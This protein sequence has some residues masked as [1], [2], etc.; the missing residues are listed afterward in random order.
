M[1]CWE[2]K[3]T[4]F[5]N[6]FIGLPY[7]PC[8][9]LAL[10]SECWC[11]ITT[12]KCIKHWCLCFRLTKAGTDMIDAVKSKLLSRNLHGKH[13]SLMKK[14]L[15]HL[16]SYP[17]EHLCYD[18][19]HFCRIERFTVILYDKTSESPKFGE[20]DLFWIVPCMDKI[21]STKM[22]YLSTFSNEIFQAGIWTTCTEAEQVIRSPTGDLSWTKDESTNLWVPVWMT[23]PEVSKA[24]KWTH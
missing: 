8:R 15:K 1:A 21:P 11:C 20:Q 17:F 2:H 10:P 16:C 7:L 6:F 12:C 9:F 19:I 18:S 14:L 13:G 23:I 3:C 24:C 22:L 5:S 4:C